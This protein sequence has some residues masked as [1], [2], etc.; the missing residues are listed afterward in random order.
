MELKMI[1]KN[2]DYNKWLTKHIK[3]T[4]D[5]DAVVRKFANELGVRPGVAYRV[6]VNE[7]SANRLKKTE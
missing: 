7:W 4:E 3:I 2:G 6:I 5:V 1:D